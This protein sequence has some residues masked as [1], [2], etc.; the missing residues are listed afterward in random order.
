MKLVMKLVCVFAPLALSSCMSAPA[1]QVPVG[2]GSNS[3]E[4]RG[5]LAIYLG[6]RGL[7]QGLWSPVEDQGVFGFEYAH[8]DSPEGFG[9]EVGLTGSGDEGK[10]AGL[11]VRGRT[12]EVYGGVRKFFGTDTVRPYLG[13]GLSAIRA[14][15]DVG[16]SDDSDTS[17][18][19]YLHAGVEFLISPTFFLG[20]DIRGLFGSSIDIGGVNGD[21]DYGQGAFTF[22]WRF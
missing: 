7:D 15:L 9:W 1:A 3:M 8:Q 6:A 5:Q 21:A 12:G 11:D 20:I 2:R 17:L 14:E 19:A 10:F 18:A 13:G 22:G 16:G 4:P